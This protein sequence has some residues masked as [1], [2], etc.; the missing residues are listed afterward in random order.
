MQGVTQT[1]K[2]LLPEYTKNKQLSSAA[3]THPQ[4]K[5]VYIVANMV[6]KHSRAAGTNNQELDDY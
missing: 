4:D 3:P 2:K 1:G 6:L 5:A